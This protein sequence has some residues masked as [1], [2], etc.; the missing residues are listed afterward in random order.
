M[1]EE[2]FIEECKKIGINPTQDQLN[3]LSKLYDY[4]IEYNKNVNLTRITAKKDVYL[5]HYY[6]SLTIVK[7]IDLNK[8]K[9]L[10]DVGTGAGFPGIILK[11][12]FSDMK[13]TLV[14]SLNKRIVYL[15][16]VIDLLDLKDIEAIHSRAEEMKEKYDVV[17]SRAV[18]RIDKLIEMC[19]PIE[20]KVLISMKAHFEEEEELI[21]KNYRYDLKKFKL[22]I[23]D[24]ERTLVTIYKK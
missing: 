2:V 11:I 5:K 12:F 10:C 3:K 9:T 22:P 19:S 17:V 14:D 13:V 1:A 7:A 15:N 20:T 4:M 18:A 8:V 23:E 24:S 21:P 6:D 16:K